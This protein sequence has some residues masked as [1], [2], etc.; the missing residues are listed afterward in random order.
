MRAWPTPGLSIDLDVVKG[1]LEPAL[2]LLRQIL[3]EPVFPQTEV[4]RQVRTRIA[5]I[6]QERSN[7][8]HRGGTRVRPHLL[9]AGRPVVATHRRH[10][11]DG[12]VHHP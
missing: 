1:N 10:P 9:R 12:V 8:A 11:R 2:D 7:A 4:A 5:E 6:E 3:T